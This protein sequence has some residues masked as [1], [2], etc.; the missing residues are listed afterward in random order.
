MVSGFEV[1]LLHL[2][3]ARRSEISK[4]IRPLLGFSDLWEKLIGGLE[5]LLPLGH[6][7]GNGFERLGLGSV[8]V[9]EVGS[10]DLLGFVLKRLKR[11]NV[12]ITQGLVAPRGPR[13]VFEGKIIALGHIQEGA[14]SREIGELEFLC[15]Q[16]LEIHVH[17]GLH[18]QVEIE[19]I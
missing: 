2:I 6:L 8:F 4:V 3:V 9:T 13:N 15:L 12:L 17:N 10:F 1:D 16:S 5:G 7:E 11:R 18:G 14:D 19:E